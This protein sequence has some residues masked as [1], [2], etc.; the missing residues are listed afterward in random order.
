MPKVIF[1]SSDTPV[2]IQK[3]NNFH[4]FVLGIWIRYGSRHEPA[5]KSGLSHF[6]EHLFFQGTGNRDAK[7]ISLEID[8][9]GGDLNAFTAREFTSLYI[10]GLK[11][12]LVKSVELIC[13]VYSNP[14]FPEE[15]IEKERSV[16]LDEIRMVNDTPEEFTHDFFMEKVFGESLGLPILGKVDTI[17]EI[18]RQDIINVFEKFYGINNTFISCA[19]N[20]DEDLLIEQLEKNLKKRNSKEPVTFKE[21]K[22]NPALEVFQRDFHEVHICIGFETVPFSSELRNSLAV[23]NCIVGGSVS[24]RLFQEIRERRGLAYNIY[25][26]VSSYSD[27]GVFGIYTACE[28]GKV[29]EI[30]RIIKTILKDLPRSISHEDIERAKNQIISQILYSSES[31]SSVMQNLAYQYIYLNRIYNLREQQSH[32]R[33]ITLKDVKEVAEFLKTERMGL[34]LVGP[35]LKEKLDF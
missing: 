1:L 6:I 26:Y 22:F 35:F 14:L 16:I 13:D 27:T 17:S 23:L 34:V 4:S 10:K 24:S 32:I 20:F 18:S 31:S 5:E 7:T 28:S 30:L 33:K 9:I 8:S 11:K 21:A 25:S 3:I 19:G 12:S 29:N 15:E 2:L